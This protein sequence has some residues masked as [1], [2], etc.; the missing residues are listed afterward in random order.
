MGLEVHPATLLLVFCF[1][2]DGSDDGLNTTENK[3]TQGEFKL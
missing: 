2:D 3:N 1:D